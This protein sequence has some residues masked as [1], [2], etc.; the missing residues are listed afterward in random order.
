MSK[1]VYVQSLFREKHTLMG[2]E[3]NIWAR[4]EVAGS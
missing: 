4:E 3:E 1:V 2:A